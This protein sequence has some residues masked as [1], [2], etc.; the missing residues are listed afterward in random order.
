MR[1]ICKETGLYLIEI[2]FQTDIAA[3]LYLYGDKPGYQK[4]KNKGKEDAD[5][6][7]GCPPCKRNTDK[8]S[9]IPIL[10]EHLEIPFDLDCRA[11]LVY[12]RT[13]LEHVIRNVLA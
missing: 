1:D 13:G 4:D 10:L 8:T 2:L 3:K 9:I 5:R 12:F 11:V 7:Y 6:Y